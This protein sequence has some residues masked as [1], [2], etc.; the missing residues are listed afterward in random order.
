MA[1]TLSFIDHIKHLPSPSPVVTQINAVLSNADASAG[2]IVGALKLDPVLTGRV[3]RL[4]NSA[5]IGIPRTIA[6]LQNA[7]VLLGVKRIR[8]LVLSSTLLSSIC[9]RRGASAFLHAFWRHSVTAALVAESIA[10]YLKRYELLE[11][12]ECFSSGILH[13]IGKLVIYEYD[14]ARFVKAERASRNLKMPFFTA[15]ESVNSH[16]AVGELLA[17]AWNFPPNLTHAIALHHAPSECSDNRRLV[18]IIHC[19]DIMVHIIGFQTITDE[20]PPQF[21]DIALAQINLEPERLKS[22]A[23]D[24]LRNEKEIETLINFFS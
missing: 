17:Q 13:D 23:N 6:S 21:D 15:E 19:A 2:D 22:I 7:V 11:T 8:S 9:I 24:T 18:A 16:M 1:A 20:I 4:A 12:E 14:T 5:Y 3:L 10:R